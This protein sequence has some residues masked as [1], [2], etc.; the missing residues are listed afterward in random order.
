MSKWAMVIDLDKCTGCGDCIAACKIENNI[1]IVDPEEANS[2]RVMFWIEMVSVYEGEFPNIKIKR[3]PKPCFHCENPPCT[4]V[5]PVH[6]TYKNDE[7]LV[8]QIYH[9][10]IG[11]RYCMVAC[12]YTV[13]V[14]NWY[15]PE[16]PVEFRKCFNPD[17]SVRTKG[18]VEKCS[19]C[20]HRLIKVKE[21]VDLEG[22]DIQDGDY[23]PACAESCPADAIY[24]GDL[25]NK[26][27]KVYNLAKSSRAKREMEN[28]G[29]EPKVVYLSKRE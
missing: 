17:V 3:F 4:K 12:P 6:A 8:G 15:E 14:F 26:E 22:R 2:G 24:F 7:G 29:T 28:L 16:W 18:V 21:E 1:A 20:A 10:C 11:C 5:C 27:S 13:K 19:F 23:M 25:E 9:R